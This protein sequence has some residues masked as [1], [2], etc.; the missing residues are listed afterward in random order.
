MDI[1]AIDRTK[2][3]RVDKSR[4]AIDIMYD[5]LFPAPEGYKQENIQP[6]Y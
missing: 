2:H 3:I 5:F 4:M 6:L 1:L